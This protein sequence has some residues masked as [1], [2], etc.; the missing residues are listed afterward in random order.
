[1][2]T[3]VF[4]GLVLLIVLIGLILCLY[5]WLLFD[6]LFVLVGGWVGCWLDVLCYY[7]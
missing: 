6:S 1:M 3:A 7:V 5:T 4:C 2:V